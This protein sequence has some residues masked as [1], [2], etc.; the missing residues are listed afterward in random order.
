MS[1]LLYDGEWTMTLSNNSYTDLGKHPGAFT[2]N[3]KL[4]MYVSMSNISATKCL[5]SGNVQF[6]QIGKYKNNTIEAFNPFSIQLFTNNTSNV[7]YDMVHQTLN[8]STGSISTKFH[9]SMAGSPDVECTS[10]IIPLRQYPYSTLQKISF[11]PSEDISELH[12]YHEIKSTKDMFSPD[13]NNNMI[14]NESINGDQGLYMLNARGRCTVVDAD[15]AVASCYIY[16]PD[17]SMQMLGF[18]IFND[19][20][21]CYQKIRFTNLEQGTEYYFYILS[22]QMSSYDFKEP[23]EEVKRISLNLRFKKSLF[24]DLV[25]LLEIENTTAWSEM[26]ASDV[27]VNKKTGLTEV[28]ETSLKRTNMMIRYSLFQI[29]SCL[30]EAVNNNINP[31]NLS[32]VDVNGNIFFDGDMWLLPLLIFLKPPIARTLLEFRYKNLEQAVQLASSFGY[33]G[34]KYPYKND[35]IGYN[36]VYWDVVSPLHIYNNALISINTWNYYRVT[37]DKEWLSQKGYIIM[38][39]VADFIT[40]FVKVKN[41]VYEMLNTVGMGSIISDNQSFTIY[42]SLMALKYTIEASY[43]LGYIPK[44]EW[45]D[46]Y[47]KLKYSIISNSGVIRYDKLSTGTTM[48]DI[49]DHLVILHPYYN[50]VHFNNFE[51]SKISTFKNNMDYYSSRIKSGFEQNVF[52][53]IMYASISATLAQIDIETNHNMTTFEQYLNNVFTQN[54]NGYWGF[55]NINNDPYIGNDISMNAAIVL[56]ILT[57]ICGLNIRG[58]TAPSNVITE[59]YRIQDSLGTYMPSTWLNI[60]ISGLGSDSKFISV[61]NMT[62]LT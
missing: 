59:Y 50:S 43:T 27:F 5:I 19:R 9:V 62:Q 35:I 34:S 16:D 60:I 61:A 13:Y 30:R 6:D 24:S 45:Q 52:N 38:R 39:N 3:G 7:N 32:Y 23:L 14:H 10:T 49:L 29:Y 36:S 11:T 18:N 56:V 44:Q 22:S 51:A 17:M 2:G 42:V 33:K 1:S 21:K 15:V 48:I 12:I 57:C 20:S 28:Q 53:N 4:G 58:S 37:L 41:G 26:W 55:M 47:M 40:S 31:L 8:M 54:F 25:A 46:I